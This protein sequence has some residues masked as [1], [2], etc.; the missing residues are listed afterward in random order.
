M[1][2]R[3]SEADTQKVAR[4]LLAHIRPAT[5]GATV[6]GLSGDLGAGK[7]TLVK[8]LGEALGVSSSIQSPTFVIAKFYPTA[9]G[10]FTE[11]VHIDAYRIEHEREMEAIGLE[12]ILAK[13][14]ALV[15]IEWPERIEGV[16]PRDAYRFAI[17]HDDT[18][19]ILDHGKN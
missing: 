1:P 9:G 15:V 19:R 7:T 6:V 11:L 10:V 14:A 18:H 5:R 3:Y 12:R 16:L 2:R 4:E 8:A 13:P 17:A